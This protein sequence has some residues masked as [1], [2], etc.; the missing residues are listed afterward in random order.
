MFAGDLFYL[1]NGEIKVSEAD[2]SDIILSLDLKDA[3]QLGLDDRQTKSYGAF[4]EVLNLD[5]KLA[6]AIGNL[7]SSDAFLNAYDQLLP[8]GVLAARAS[9]IAVSDQTAFALG[10]RL[11]SL[12]RLS[13]AEKSTA[14]FQLFGS[15]YMQ[16]PVGDYV[17]FEGETYGIAG[18]FDWSALGADA[19]GL[20]F[21]WSGSR[22][23]DDGAAEEEELMADS[24]QVGAYGSWSAGPAFLSL[25]GAGGYNRY[26]TDRYIIINDYESAPKADWDGYQYAGSV[27]TGIDGTFGNFRIT[28]TLG[29][30]YLYVQ[31][32]GFNEAGGSPG[33]NLSVVLKAISHRSVP[34]VRSSWPYAI[35]Q[36]NGSTLTPSLRGGIRQE[37]ETD[38]LVTEARFKNGSEV[39]DIVSGEIPENGVI[40][41]VGLSYDILG[42]YGGM[43]LEAG[44]TGLIEDDFVRHSGGMNFR[45]TF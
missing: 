42:Y 26:R 16:D 6:S 13:H 31:Q 36:S 35:K 15:Y 37:F 22:I 9:A 3:D 40:G 11:D 19:L 43:H 45:F 7:S 2:P 14:W 1:Y 44:Y 20:S 10:G 38:P 41:G 25:H 33:T 29:I 34:Q 4:V 23:S 8:T 21:S 27:R 30:D 17:G 28:P 39:F 12:R 5:P 32:N 18:G 24:L